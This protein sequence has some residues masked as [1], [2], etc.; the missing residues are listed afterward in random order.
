MD[1]HGI[2]RDKETRASPSKQRADEFTTVMVID[3]SAWSHWPRP[4]YLTEC[5][6]ISRRGVGGAA[7]I[8]RHLFFFFFFLQRSI[9]APSPV[10]AGGRVACWLQILVLFRQAVMTFCAGW[11]WLILGFRSWHHL[12]LSRVILRSRVKGSMRKETPREAP[13]TCL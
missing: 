6:P 2:S 10:M 9:F 4:Y 8:S 11:S 1:P 7:W 5:A 3:Q 13:K 12:E